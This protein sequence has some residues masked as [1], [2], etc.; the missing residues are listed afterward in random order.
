M[1]T[2][3]VWM[4]LV[5]ALAPLAGYLLGKF[6]KEELAPGKKYFIAAKHVLFTLSI[7]VF[8]FAFKWQLWYVVIGLTVLF[9]YIAFA[10]FRNLLFAQL[11]LALAFA[12]TAD[13]PLEFLCAALVFLHGLPAGTLLTSQKKGL[14][15]A[16][17]AGALFLVI[18]TG[19][20]YFL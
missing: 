13:T 11:V 4:T 20:Q 7:I 17:M 2:V 16:I 5:L 10:V 19:L 9:A 1:G 18:A 12:L 8:L 3:S 6:T 14:H 15:D